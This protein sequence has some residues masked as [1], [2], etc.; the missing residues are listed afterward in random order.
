MAEPASALVALSSAIQLVAAC[1]EVSTF[2]Q[3]IPSNYKQSLGILRSIEAEVGI[4]AAAVGHVR[5]WLEKTAISRPEVDDPRI[6]GVNNALNQ[7]NESMR[8]LRRTL[9]KFSAKENASNAT[10]AW[11]RR[12]IRTKFVF[13]ED[14]LKLHLGELRQQAALVQFTLTALQL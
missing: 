4:F 5:E 3:K 12:W 6:Q 13:Q 1:L 9:E 2:L 11:S 8:E 7:F 14:T 10:G